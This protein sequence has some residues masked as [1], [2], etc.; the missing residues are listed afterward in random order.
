[1]PKRRE[2][3]MSTQF[4]TDKEKEK[5]PGVL[6][7]EDVKALFGL[8]SEFV[9]DRDSKD[10]LA[11]T[12]DALRQL[13]GAYGDHL[14]DLMESWPDLPKALRGE[15]ARARARLLR[16]RLLEGLF[17]KPR[18]QSGADRYALVEGPDAHATRSLISG[19]GMEI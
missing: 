14:V 3:S 2:K 9:D 4:M 6:T 10:Q 16:M 17:Q 19:K 15:E 13:I 18:V 7:S 12:G 11:F 8:F 5:G 1:M